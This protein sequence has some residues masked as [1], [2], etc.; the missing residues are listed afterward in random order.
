MR[1]DTEL[2]IKGMEVLL[3]ELGKVEAERFISLI[4]R[5]PFD[6]TRWQRDLWKDKKVEELS[7]EAMEFRKKQAQ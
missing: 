1:T 7:K 2:K 4:K 5:E 3:K 6:Y